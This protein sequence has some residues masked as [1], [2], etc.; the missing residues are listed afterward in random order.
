MG[1]IYIEYAAVCVEC[2]CI[3]RISICEV[4]NCYGN[5]TY[6][7]TY[8]CVYCNAVECVCAVNEIHTE[9]LICNS[10]N[11]ISIYCSEEACSRSCLHA[12]ICICESS[13]TVLNLIFCYCEITCS[14]VEYDFACCLCVEDLVVCVACLMSYS[15]SFAHS[16][17]SCCAVILSCEL[18]IEVSCEGC[19]VSDVCLLN[20]V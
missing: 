4:N 6:I 8:S 18:S 16:K 2:K 13:C 9:H 20:H 1:S 10:G 17:N 19:L 3:C 11:L 14:C 7:K 5:S 15:H 12:L